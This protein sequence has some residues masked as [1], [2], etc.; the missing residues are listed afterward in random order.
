MKRREPAPGLSVA[1]RTIASAPSVT[2][3]GPLWP[4]RSVAVQ[5]GSAALTLMSPSALAY[6]VVSIVRATLDAV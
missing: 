3:C 5:P 6:W 1:R 2:V 4:L